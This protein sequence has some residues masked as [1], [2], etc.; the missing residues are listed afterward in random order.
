M[1][2]L[3]RSANAVIEW[4]KAQEVLKE[5]KVLLDQQLPGGAISRAYYAAFHAATAL[6]ISKGLEVKSH[7]GLGKMFSLHFIKTGLM[8]SK[9]SRILSLAQKYREEADYNSEYVFTIDDAQKTY[10]EVQDL[11]MTAE[12]ILRE[13]GV[14]G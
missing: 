2:A 5:A 4:Q 8:D 6:L 3:N 12:A 14:L 7:Q 13:K 1:N 9:F 10:Q 11:C